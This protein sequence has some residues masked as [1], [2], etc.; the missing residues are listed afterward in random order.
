MS[1]KTFTKVTHKTANSDE[2]PQIHLFALIRTSSG[3]IVTVA[4]IKSASNPLH[5]PQTSK[6]TKSQ[7]H[8]TGNFPPVKTINTALPV[9]RS[10]SVCPVAPANPSA[11]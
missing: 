10:G 9:R 6:K 5:E 7:H 1:S 2:I 3:R 8:F 11:S 4:H